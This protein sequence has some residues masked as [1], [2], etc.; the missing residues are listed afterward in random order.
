MT[1][2]HH[3]PD[4]TADLTPEEEKRATDEQSLDA[5][6]THEV[7]RREGTKELERTPSALGWSALAAGLSMGLSLLAQAALHHALP[8]AEWRPLVTK[9]G[10]AVGF[11]AVILGSQQLFTENT[12]TPMVPLLAKRTG[13]MFRKVAVLWAVVFVANILGTLLFAWAA[14]RTQVF[15]LELRQTFE[16][17]AHETM[18]PSALAHFARGI[19]AGWII[20]LMVWMLPAA[21]GS[22]VLVI[23]IMTWLIGAAKLSHVIAGSIEAFY[24]A[25]IGASTHWHALTH[26]ILP[27]LAGNM[28]GG[29]TLVA[30]LNHTQVEADKE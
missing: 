10:Y 1:H 12:L 2:H 27:A 22:R 9:L 5:A 6:T 19:A 14:A 4:A 20:A 8:D 21:E 25:A 18:R 29:I 13:H 24:L 7:I 26:F 11:L 15:S 23:V 17:I 30:A 16:T 3:D 28:L